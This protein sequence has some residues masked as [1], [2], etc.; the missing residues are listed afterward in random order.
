VHQNKRSGEVLAACPRGTPKKKVLGIRD[1]GAWAELLGW[2]NRKVLWPL[3]VSG[4]A[5]GV[6]Q[7]E[8]A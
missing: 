7:E 1:F 8:V 4:G 6:S 3:E 2:L 5:Q